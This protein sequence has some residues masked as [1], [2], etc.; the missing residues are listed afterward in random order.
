MGG[1]NWEKRGGGS[2]ISR[3]CGH[4]KKRLPKNKKEGGWS[5]EEG[6]L[7][8]EERPPKVSFTAM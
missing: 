8:R 5:R 2:K 3:S 4:K 7:G 1:R 6:G